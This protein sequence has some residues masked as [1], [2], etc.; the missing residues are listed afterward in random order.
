[1]ALMTNSWRKRAAQN[2]HLLVFIQD[3]TGLLTFP[4]GRDG[5][6]KIRGTGDRWCIRYQG[7]R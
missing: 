3:L 6:R 2:A 7:R 5:I 1:V 4:A